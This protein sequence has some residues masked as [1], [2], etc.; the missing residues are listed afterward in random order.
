[1]KES[2]QVTNLTKKYGE[3]VVLDNINISFEKGKIYSIIGVNGA[4]KT[5]FFSCVDGDILFDTGEIT[6]FEDGITRK[7]EFDDIG[8]VSDSPVLPD[9]LTGYE[10]IS[11]FTNFH[12][13]DNK[14]EIDA[15]FDIVRINSTDR[16]RLIKNYSFGMKNKLQL[17]CAIIRKP[18]IILLDEPLSSFDIV[19]SHEIKEL[20]MKMKNDHIIVMSTHIMQLAQDVSDEIVLLRDGAMKKLTELDIKSPDFEQYLINELS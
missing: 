11:F 15:Y 12:K 4:G 18:K 3:K 20:L 9:F 8:L 2:L 10:F 5:T 13:S 17:L 16:H 19:V 7:V 6:I 1:M 14:E